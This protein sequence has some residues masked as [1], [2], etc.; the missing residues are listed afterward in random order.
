MSETKGF[1]KGDD[2]WWRIGAE[3][4]SDRGLRTWVYHNMRGVDRH[5]G[6]CVLKMHTDAYANRQK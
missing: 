4:I 6:T 1:W 3:E 5:V 2:L